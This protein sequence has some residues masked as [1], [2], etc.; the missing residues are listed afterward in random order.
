MRVQAIKTQKI[1]SDRDLNALLDR[2]V[3]SLEER[4]VLA[5]TS[6][7]VSIC[8]GRTIPAASA[9]K[10]ALVIAEADWFLPPSASR[11]HVHLTI[12]DGSAAITG[13]LLGVVGVGPGTPAW[14]A[15][16]GVADA[17]GR[18]LKYTSPP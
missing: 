1:T 13:I 14:R 16:D 2:Y 9:D 4:S 5:I 11:Y 18:Q 7:I 17:C 8:Q 15:R 6:K 12:V 10:E 3:T